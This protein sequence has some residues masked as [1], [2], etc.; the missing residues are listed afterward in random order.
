MSCT[1]GRRP[2][3]R[4]SAARRET[5]SGASRASKSS[6][7]TTPATKG[8]ARAIHHLFGLLLHRVRRVLRL[9]DDLLDGAL[10][11]SGGLVALAFAPQLVVVDQRTRCFLRAPLGF[12]ELG[13]RAHL[14]SPLIYVPRTS[15]RLGARRGPGGQIT[16]KQLS[17]HPEA[18][19]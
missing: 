10:D 17:C 5:A 14:V 11:L 16:T 8:V 9:L 13:L 7:P 6:Q 18:L 4:G 3:S 2:T 15:T 1:I 12:V 19:R